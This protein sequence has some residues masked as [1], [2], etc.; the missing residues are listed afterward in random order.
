MKND[1]EGHQVSGEAAR[2]IRISVWYPAVPSDVAPMSFSAY[3][4][5]QVPDTSFSEYNRRIEEADLGGDGKGVRGLF[6]TR[7]EVDRL[8]RTPT[9][10]VLHAAPMKGSYP[11]IV[12]SLGQNDYTQE[13]VILWEYLANHGY[14]V[15]TVPQLGTSPRRFS[16]FIHDPPSYEA[17]VRDLEFVVYVM[18]SFPNVNP[19]KTA[20]VGM[21]MGGV[22][23]LLLAMRNN[24]I[25]A[26]VGLD[27]S[28]IAGQVSFAYKYWEAPYYDIAR[29]KIPMMVMYRGTDD[30][31]RKWD[32]VDSMK[33]ADRYLLRFPDLVHVDFTSY[34]MLTLNAPTDE[35]DEYALKYRT[36]KRAADGFQLVCSYTLRFLDAYLKGDSQA[37]KTIYSK[38]AMQAVDTGIVE[39]EFR[40][41]LKA[42]TEEEFFT[43]IREQGLDA[44]IRVYRAA[45]QKYPQQNLIRETVIR[46]IGNEMTYLNDAAAAVDVFKLY[47]E[48]FPASSD[49][50]EKLGEGYSLTGNKEMAIRNFKRALE[51]N[52]KNQNAIEQLKEMMK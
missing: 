22:Y 29:L 47:V 46:R 12:Y 43:I 18:H 50:Y 19:A 9:A 17:Q 5:F 49:A 10:A 16:L 37:L 11:L 32:I 44:A 27:P 48:A 2:P 8:M 25:D 13:N 21:S 20:A 40:E 52:P 7:D 30:S 4:H 42:P 15:A 1:Y 14:I 33:Y 35:L 34:P 45:K 24:K 28:F 6:K 51:L 23:A 38:P 31:D 39:S 36:Q 41:G 3:T 26:L